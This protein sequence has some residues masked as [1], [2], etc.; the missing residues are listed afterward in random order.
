M[1]DYRLICNLEDLGFEVRDTIVLLYNNEQLNGL[2]PDTKFIF[3]LRK[4]VERKYNR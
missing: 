4:S 1:I 3:M 2:K